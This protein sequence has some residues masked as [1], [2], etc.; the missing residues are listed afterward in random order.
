MFLWRASL[1]KIFS[2]FFF[3]QDLRCNKI[4]QKGTPF[5]HDIHICQFCS[6]KRGVFG[7][8]SLMN[9]DS[10]FVCGRFTTWKDDQRSAMVCHAHKPS[11]G[12]PNMKMCF[13]CKRPAFQ[14]PIKAY[15]CPS[16]GTGGIIKKCAMLVGE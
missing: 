6:M 15:L 11:P 12:P 1:S 2:I 8:M 3:F 5:A 7:E 14:N 10:C 16:C 4:L 9:K 13:L